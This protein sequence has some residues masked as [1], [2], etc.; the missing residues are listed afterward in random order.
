MNSFEWLALHRLEL[1]VDWERVRRGESL[2]DIEPLSMWTK[3]ATP[4]NGPTART[5]RHLDNQWPPAA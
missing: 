5:L 4:S 1:Q 3:K 2:L